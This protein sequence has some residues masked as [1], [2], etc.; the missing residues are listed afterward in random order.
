[1]VVSATAPSEISSRVR[2]SRMWST[3][4]IVPS[5]LAAAAALSWV[6]PRQNFRGA[7]GSV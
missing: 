3:R 6:E 4:D 5:G 7:H 1:M 2:S